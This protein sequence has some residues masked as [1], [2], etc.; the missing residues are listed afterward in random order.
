MCEKPRAELVQNRM[1]EADVDQFQAQQ[2]FLAGRGADRV[3]GLAVGQVRHQLQ[4]SSHKASVGE[5]VLLTG[6]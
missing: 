5:R 1:V 2:L 6:S 3:D 4:A